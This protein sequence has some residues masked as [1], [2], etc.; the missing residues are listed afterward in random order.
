MI[1]EVISEVDKDQIPL[2][3]TALFDSFTKIWIN[4]QF[5][6]AL[7]RPEDRRRFIE[8]LAFKLWTEGRIRLSHQELRRLVQDTLNLVTADEVE[9]FD[10]DIRTCSFL[11]RDGQGNYL[12]THRSFMEFFMTKHCLRKLRDPG[13]DLIELATQLERSMG[14]VSLTYDEIEPYE[15]VTFFLI[16][17]LTPEDYEILAG[18]LAHPNPEVRMVTVRILGA[19]RQAHW[20]EYLRHLLAIETNTLVR[21]QIYISL[22]R[23]GDRNAIA[24]YVGLLEASQTL[25]DEN[26]DYTLKYFGSLQKTLE[27]I[28]NRLRDEAY[29]HMWSIDVLTL[30]DIGHP[31]GIKI[32]EGFRPEDPAIK[33]RVDR[34]L[35]GL[36]ALRL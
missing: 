32:L 4:A 22:G 10:V 29:S 9:R 36:Q 24:E 19:T 17:M 14:V 16:H 35:A 23:L 1:A 27:T 8:I 34:A 2:D 3:T 26:K 13:L 21:R 7:L 15:G 5:D 25:R 33:Q 31:E 28:S 12:F 6:R 18:Q 30:E 20:F 11:T